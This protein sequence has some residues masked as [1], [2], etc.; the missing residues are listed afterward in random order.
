MHKTFSHLEDKKLFYAKPLVKGRIINRP[1]RYVAYVDLNGKTV[2]CHTPVG[3]R[4]GGLT[5][6]N[7]PCLLSGPHEGRATEYTVEAIGL[8]EESDPDFQW[9]AIH[10]GA[11]NAYVKEFLLG[12][13]MPSLAPGLEQSPNAYLHPERKLDTSRID[14]YIDVPN[15]KELWI[16]VKTPLI[17]LHTKIPEYIPVKTDY[18]SDSVGGR[19]PK[20]MTA[21]NTELAAGKRVILLGAF[22]YQNNIHSSDQLKLSENLD[23][24]NLLTNGKTLGLESWQVTF[25][26]DELGVT[27]VSYENIM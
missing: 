3:G 19:M 7:L 8:G 2:K 24:D 22:G 11:V 27:F 13:L 21:L 23:L 25:S 18:A 17:K 4:I 12:G 6:D 20:Q 9:L 15:E 26:I 1:N 14:F 5:I 16:E 10:Q